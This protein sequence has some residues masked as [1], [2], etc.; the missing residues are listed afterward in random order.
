MPRQLRIQYPE[1]MY[2]AMSRGDR[3][4][5][6]SLDDVDRQDFFN[7]PTASLCPLAKCEIEPFPVAIGGIT[8]ESI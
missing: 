4:E 3:Q 8:P 2:H 1:A 5:R 7:L 6:I